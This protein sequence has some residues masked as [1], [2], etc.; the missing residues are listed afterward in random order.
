MKTR[1]R[2]TTLG[3]ALLGSLLFGGC[4]TDDESRQHKCERVREHFI[5]LR[6]SG[7]PVQNREPH[8]VALRQ[9][10]GERFEAPSTKPA[11]PTKPAADKKIKDD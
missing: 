11:A 9:A 3:C 8:R 1:R 6:V 10:L 5:E 7:L 2:A 4:A